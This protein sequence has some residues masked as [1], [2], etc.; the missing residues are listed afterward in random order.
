MRSQ[1]ISYPSKNRLFYYIK[2]STLILLSTYIL[3][4]VCVNIV[5]EIKE[6]TNHV[7]GDRHWDSESFWQSPWGEAKVHKG[8]DIFA[9]RKSEILSPINGFVLSSTYSEN[10]GYHLYIFGPKF[11]VY[12][13]AHLNYKGKTAFS[14]VKKGQ[15]IGLVGNSGNAIS[16]PCHLHFSIFSLFPIVKHFNSNEPLGWL[17]MFYLDPSYSLKGNSDV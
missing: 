9:K 7:V 3:G 13:F 10:G 5:G 1:N 16:K 12:Y 2:F 11:R 17:K 15:Y 8:I 6:L 4:F 14:F